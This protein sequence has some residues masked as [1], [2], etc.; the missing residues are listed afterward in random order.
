MAWLFPDG[1]VAVMRATPISAKGTANISRLKS[2]VIQRRDP[3]EA[4]CA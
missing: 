1:V 2:R 3:S 4:I